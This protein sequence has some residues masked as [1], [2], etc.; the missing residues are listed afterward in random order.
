MKNKRLFKVYQFIITLIFVV[1]LIAGCA[2]NGEIESATNE[3]KKSSSPIS[4]NEGV[5]LEVTSEAF[6]D[7]IP[8]GEGQKY[9]IR[10]SFRIALRDWLEYKFG[11]INENAFD[12]VNVQI[13]SINYDGGN[14]TFLKS[15][16]MQI[17]LSGDINGIYF[18]EEMTFEQNFSRSAVE[19]PDYKGS[20]LSIKAKTNLDRFLM[21]YV[22][23]IKSY[24]KEN[25]ENLN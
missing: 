3:K 13:L 9:N 10:N 16:S 5:A 22:E 17:R 20:T 14:N 11:K 15:V 4:A 23:K 2:F 8:I 12:E 7:D 19:N 25:V 1:T 24:L 6:S 18:D 21:L